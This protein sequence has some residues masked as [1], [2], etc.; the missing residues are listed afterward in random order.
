MWEESIILLPR[1]CQHAFLS[2]TIPNAFEFAQWVAATHAIRCHVVYTEYRPVPLQHYLMPAGGKSMFLVV[3]GADGSAQPGACTRARVG[4]KRPHIIQCV[5][6]RGMRMRT[7]FS[8]VRP[9]RAHCVLP[10]ARR[11]EESIRLS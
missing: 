5:S 8:L 9:S 11:R 4:M 10:V 2:A 1:S 7:I 3:R 6:E